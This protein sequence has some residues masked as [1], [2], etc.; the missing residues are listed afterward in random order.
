LK[1]IG[2]MAVVYVFCDTNAPPVLIMQVVVPS[3][4]PAVEVT[5]AV[6]CFLILR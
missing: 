3:D 5:F 4:I 2:T 6:T 1:T